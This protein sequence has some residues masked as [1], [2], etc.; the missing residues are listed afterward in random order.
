MAIASC[1]VEHAFWK[2]TDSPVRYLKEFI[3]VH[4]QCQFG[5][6]FKTQVIDVLWCLH[7]AFLLDPL[8]SWYPLNERECPGCI[9]QIDSDYLQIGDQELDV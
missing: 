4:A 6:L 5:Q 1:V 8:Q 3:E 9:K 2:W 7:N